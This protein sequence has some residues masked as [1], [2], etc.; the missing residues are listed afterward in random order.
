M[1]YSNVQ[2]T[3]E[4]YFKY[5]MQY[6]LLSLCPVYCIVVYG[7][8]ALRYTVY[9]VQYSINYT[10]YCTVYGV[11]YKL[12]KISMVSTNLNATNINKH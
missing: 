9:I 6:A 3:I 2:C 10:A 7:V 8:Y 5:S 4:F 11:Y 1:V 12:I